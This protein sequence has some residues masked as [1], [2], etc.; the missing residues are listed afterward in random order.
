[1]MSYKKCNDDNVSN[2]KKILE[3]ELKKSLVRGGYEELF[4]DDLLKMWLCD[5][6]SPEVVLRE[7]RVLEGLDR[8]L[9]E[10]NGD[11]PI[12][13]WLGSGESF[14]PDTYLNRSPSATKSATQFTKENSPLKGLWHK[15]YFV[16]QEYFLKNNIENQ[17]KRYRDFNFN[18]LGAM[19]VRVAE[20]KVTGEWIVFNREGDRNCYLCL[21]KHAEGDEAIFERMKKAGAL[22]DAI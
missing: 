4:F 2:A 9:M 5:A 12:A 10:V 21:A 6:I 15:H 16:N 14:E 20:G 18:P 17:R 13:I 8:P 11:E 22:K 19:V 1:M 3:S 7:L